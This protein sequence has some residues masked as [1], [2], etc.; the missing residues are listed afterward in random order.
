VLEAAHAWIRGAAATPWFAWVHLF[1]PHA[2]YDAPERRVADPYDNEV[3]FTDATLGRFLGALDAEGRLG[4]TVVVV[5]ADHG[6]SLGDHGEMTHGL[7][8]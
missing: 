6:E 8:A 7:F 1:D 2:P 5:T 3:A 4:T